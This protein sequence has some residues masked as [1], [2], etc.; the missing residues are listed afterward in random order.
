ML[1]GFLSDLKQDVNT[2]NAIGKDAESHTELKVKLFE[3]VEFHV[4]VKELSQLLTF[5][6]Y[7]K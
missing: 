5:I 1:I 3:F 7:C 4:V 6:S 2:L